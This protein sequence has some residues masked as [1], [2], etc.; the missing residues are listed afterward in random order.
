MWGPL[1]HP[2]ERVPS[3]FGAREGVSGPGT[4]WL[5][6]PGEPARA[7][8]D[9]EA[10]GAGGEGTAP[11]MS[12]RLQGR[13]GGGGRWEVVAIVTRAQHPEAEPLHV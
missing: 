6:S 4:T 13:P 2:G 9:A 5:K 3:T 10:A 7:G 12:A 1:E 8:A 11:A